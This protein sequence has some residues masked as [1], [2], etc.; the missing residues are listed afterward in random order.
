M[1][2]ETTQ[3]GDSCEW[4]FRWNLSIDWNTLRKF[5]VKNVISDK[6]C[7]I[8]GLIEG[9]F[10]FFFTSMHENL[11]FFRS[12]LFHEKT[13][14]FQKFPNWSEV[15]D[16]HWLHSLSIL[17]I[18]AI[19]VGVPY[20]SWRPLSNTMW[21]I[22]FHLCNFTEGEVKSSVKQSKKKLLTA[23]KKWFRKSLNGINIIG[24]ICNY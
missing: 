20:A 4:N 15:P 23:G 17:F 8:V 21:M 7:A 2:H 9:P 3:G 18:H 5:S 13:K 14:N 6:R 19:L 24:A 10:L 22:S 1:D 16:K 12:F 11:C